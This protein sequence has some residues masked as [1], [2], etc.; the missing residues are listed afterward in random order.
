M[1]KAQ[2]EDTLF[3]RGIRYNIKSKEN[4]R[5]D[6]GSDDSSNSDDDSDDNGMACGFRDDDDTR[7]E[8]VLF[9][10]DAVAGGSCNV[11]SYSGLLFRHVLVGDSVVA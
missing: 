6:D 4:R 8:S 10:Q 3:S 11:E 1:S 2:F 5:N 9:F 7:R